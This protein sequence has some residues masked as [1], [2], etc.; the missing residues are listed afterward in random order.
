M[1]SLSRI[2]VLGRLLRRCATPRGPRQTDAA[3]TWARTDDAGRRRL[4]RAAVDPAAA[5]HVE[6]ADARHV[7]DMLAAARAGRRPLDVIA[8]IVT[9][10]LVLSTI[11]GFG[12]AAVPGSATW[13]LLGGLLAMA[14]TCTVGWRR[15]A[16][17]RAGA[18]AVR[19]VLRR[20]AS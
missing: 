12:R 7:V 11:W 20:A 14:V 8:P 1:S 5:R 15:A 13:F 3:R 19:Q 17:R 4:L 9:G 16:V 18:R 6:R 10:L 2:D